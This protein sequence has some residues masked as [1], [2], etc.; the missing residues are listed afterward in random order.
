MLGPELKASILI[1]WF[2]ISLIVALVIIAAAAYPSVESIN[3]IPCSW[4][5]IGT[6]SPCPLCGMTR[7]FVLIAHGRAAA[8]KQLNRNA[9][10]LFTIFA[11]NT[12]TI[13]LF[14]VYGRLVQ[15]LIAECRHL[16]ASQ[17]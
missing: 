6:H 5:G 10:T 4:C 13:A 17:K 9:F 15:S 12:I 7:A 8:A 3:I 11:L 2:I 16:C 1:S 14:F